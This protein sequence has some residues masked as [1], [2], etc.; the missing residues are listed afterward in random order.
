MKATAKD[1]RIPGVKSDKKTVGPSIQYLKATQMTG[2]T[3]IWVKCSWMKQCSQKEVPKLIKDIMSCC[4]NAKL[5][6]LRYHQTEKE[7]WNIGAE[8]G[9]SSCGRKFLHSQVC[10][11]S[12]LFLSDSLKHSNNTP[13]LKST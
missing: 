11:D 2:F 5:L 1:T 4:N 7:Q 9:T 12:W 10:L 3:G 13:P 6:Y 8:V